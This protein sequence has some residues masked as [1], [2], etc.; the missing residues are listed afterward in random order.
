[1]VLKLD[2]HAAKPD[3]RFKTFHGPVENG[4]CEIFL[5]SSAVEYLS[6]RNDNLFK[7]ESHRDR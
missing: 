2:H 4:V 6:N 1:M 5:S 7:Q 3:P